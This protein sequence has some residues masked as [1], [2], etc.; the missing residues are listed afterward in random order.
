ML[1]GFFLFICQ[2]G[3]KVA[4]IDIRAV[5]LQK[6]LDSFHEVK[7]FQLTHE[8]DDVATFA[9]AETL[10]HVEREVKHQRGCLLIMEDT[11][12]LLAIL[13]STPKGSAWT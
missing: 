8:A 1:F 2:L 10:I 12:A 7:A 5:C 11:T 13:A 4:G 3:I 6:E 9:T